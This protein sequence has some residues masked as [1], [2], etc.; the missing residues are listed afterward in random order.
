MLPSVLGLM[1]KSPTFN[2]FTSYIAVCK[3]IFLNFG[4]L[5]LL[6]YVFGLTTVSSFT[7]TAGNISFDRS[8][9]SLSKSMLGWIYFR[10]EGKHNRWQSWFLSSDLCGK[11]KDISTFKSSCY[12]SPSCLSRCFLSSNGNP[13]ITALMN[14]PLSYGGL[15]CSLFRSLFGILMNPNSPFYGITTFRNCLL[16]FNTLTVTTIYFFRVSGVYFNRL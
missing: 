7:Y 11:F 10:I 15:D 5:I 4:W 6:N 2:Y 13:V 1:R 12:W 14:I 16:I 3:L 9:F 8:K